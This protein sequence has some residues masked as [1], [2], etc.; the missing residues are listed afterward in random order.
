MCSASTARAYTFGMESWSVG[1]DGDEDVERHAGMHETRQTTAKP[2]LHLVLVSDYICPWCYVGLARL[3]KLRDE[4]DVTLTACAYDLRPGIPPEGL[5]RS[6]VSQGRTYPEGYL[7]NL[8]LTALEAGI[9]MK[10]PPLVP[11]TR[12]AHEATEFASENG[13]DL[14][15]VHRALFRA[16]FEEERNIGDTEVV[17]EVCAAAGVEHNA[18]RSALDEGRYRE[19][20]ERQMGW[21]RSQGISGVPAVI[22]NMRFA[23]TGAQDY[24]VFR[25]V[26]QRIVAQSAQP[27]G[28]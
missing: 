3:E 23:V 6:E 10:R 21:G 28:G 22:F 27:T 4:F 7:D 25:D 11:N 2:P 16:Y 1:Y 17:V 9:E 5:P 15:A 20:I 26:A 19:E 8:R 12:K 18:L 24:E 13:G 14:W